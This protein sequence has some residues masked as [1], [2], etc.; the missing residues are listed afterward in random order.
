MVKIVIT[1][2]LLSLVFII[3]LML[4]LVGCSEPSNPVSKSLAKQAPQA[5]T[6]FSSG[7]L[8]KE[9]AQPV[10]AVMTTFLRMADVPTL[11][12]MVPKEGLIVVPYG[13]RPSS[14]RG[15][16]GEILNQ[17]LEGL[18]KNSK[19]EIIAYEVYK[20]G[21]IGLVVK[22]LNPVRVRPPHS[23]TILF[24]DLT[25]VSLDRSKGG[26]WQITMAAPDTRGMLVKALSS[27]PFVML[28]EYSQPLMVPAAPRDV[29]AGVAKM[30]N[31]ADAPA[32]V[33][34]VSEHGLAIVPYGL[35]TRE[36]G[37]KDDTLVKTVTSLVKGAEARVVAYDLSEEG[38]IGLVVKGLNRIQVQPV[39]GDK[40][41]MTSLAFMSIK[42]DADGVWRLWLIAPD[43]YGLL[44]KTMYK[45]PFESYK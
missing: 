33:K 39:F 23:P 29:I 31:Q 6:E 21:H 34:M 3:G 15:L 17:A 28:S 13:V 24:T 37:L 38:R 35:V 14:Q 4:G 19:P 20:S 18:L 41:T 9:Q 8:D 10:I 44:A 2:R 22:G 30:L 16:T 36:T 27:S 42:L 1:G 7:D 43:N 45:P 26:D 5:L 25:Y 12:S 40:V 11:A 32:L